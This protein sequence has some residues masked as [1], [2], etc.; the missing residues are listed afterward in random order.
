MNGTST[1][2]TICIGVIGAPFETVWSIYWRARPVQRPWGYLFGE[3]IEERVDCGLRGGSVR[4]GLAHHAQARGHGGQ[5]SR[6]R[7]GLDTVGQLARRLRARKRSRQLGLHGLEVPTDTPF[8]FR[9]MGSQFHSRRHQQ[10]T[11]SAIGAAG[12][13]SIVGKPSPQAGYWGA[14]WVEFDIHSGLALRHVAVN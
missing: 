8:N 13:F 12:A 10:A 7:C 11:A 5:Q 6:R 2:Q 4:N 3:L 14:A 1:A 9:V